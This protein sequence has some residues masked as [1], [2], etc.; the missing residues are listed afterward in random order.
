MKDDSLPKTDL[1][2]RVGGSFKK[3]V[4]GNGNFLG[5]CKEEGLG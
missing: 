4:K 2:L 3:N 1:F 5:G